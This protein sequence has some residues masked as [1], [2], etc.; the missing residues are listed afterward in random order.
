MSKRKAVN[1][2]EKYLSPVDV[3][4]FRMDILEAGTRLVPMLTV[5]YPDADLV[6]AALYNVSEVVEDFS[7]K[8]KWVMSQ[9]GSA[10]DDFVMTRG[11]REVS[12]IA[13]VIRLA[14]L[15][16]LTRISF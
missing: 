6:S 7:M 3:K 2:R 10:K 16:F 15:V 13:T 8:G 12:S 4:E 11:I 9:A 5:E 1:R 14:R